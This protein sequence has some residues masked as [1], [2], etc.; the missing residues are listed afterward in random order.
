MN[1][2]NKFIVISTVACAACTSFGALANTVSN[3]TPSAQTAE[4]NKPFSLTFTFAGNQASVGCGLVIDWGDGKIEKFRV[5]EGQQLLP[6]YTVEHTYTAPGDYKVKISGELIARGLRTVGPCDVK[7]EGTVAVIDPIEAAKQAEAKAA[8]ERERR[9]RQE[10]EA[11]ARKERAEAQR[12]EAAARAAKEAEERTKREAEQAARM[13]EQ[14][15]AHQAAMSTALSKSSI[16]T[17]EQFV[18]AFKSRYRYAYD[19]PELKCSTADDNDAAFLIQAYNPARARYG[20]SA[21][22]KFYY[23]PKS[24]TVLGISGSGG[25]TIYNVKNFIDAS[26]ATDMN[27]SGEIDWENLPPEQQKLV[28]NKLTSVGNNIVNQHEFRIAAGYEVAEVAKA[29][30]WDF[31]VINT[32]QMCRLRF[33]VQGMYQGNSVRRT[34]SCGIGRILKKNDGSYMATAIEFSGGG[35]R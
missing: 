16:K 14:K 6:P 18:D 7:R 26:K 3:I 11:Q 23:Q 24:E 33:T 15:K 31:D 22:S 19:W 5:G 1:Q 32:P 4:P 10:A 2:F 29:G 35:C 34:V 28:C 20:A 21:Y 13:A 9:E 12:A 25:R 17:C 30:N 27:A 8:A